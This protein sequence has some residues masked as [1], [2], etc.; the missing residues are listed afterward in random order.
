MRFDKISQNL[1]VY[2]IDEALGKNLNDVI[3]IKL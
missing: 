2:Y 3:H 1:T